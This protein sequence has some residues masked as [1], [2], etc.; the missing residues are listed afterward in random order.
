MLVQHQV[1]VIAATSTPAAR[2]ATTTFPIVFEIAADP[3]HLGL[4]ASL[5]RRAGPS[6]YFP[7]AKPL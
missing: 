1:A 7:T 3:V 2:A 5:N 6:Y 4:V